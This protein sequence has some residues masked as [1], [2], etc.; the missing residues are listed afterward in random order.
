MKA[1][2]YVGIGG[3]LGAM[4]R[5]GFT[6]LPIKNEFPLPTLMINVIGAFIIGLIAQLALKTSMQP[7]LV[8]LIKTGL[9]GGFTTFSTFSLESM[10]LIQK[11]AW[12]QAGSYILFSIVFCLLAVYLGMQFADLLIRKFSFWSVH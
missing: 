5:Y 6:L 9:C 2:L 11:K 12:L 3:A 4:A 10:Q 7:D 1:F 8:L